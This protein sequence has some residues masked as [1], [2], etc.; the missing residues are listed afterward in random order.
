MRKPSRMLPE[1]HL[2]GI[3][4]HT[5]GCTQQ[6]RCELLARPMRGKLAASWQVAQPLPGPWALPRTWGAPRLRA[7]RW[8]CCAPSAGR[9]GAPEHHGLVPGQRGAGHGVGRAV[10]GLWGRSG[11]MGIAGLVRV[12]CKAVAHGHARQRPRLLSQAG[13]PGGTARAAPA[14]AAAEAEEKVAHTHGGAREGHARLAVRHKVRVAPGAQRGGRRRRGLHR[15]RR[16][17]VRRRG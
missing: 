16:R 12:P 14:A 8:P 7:A 3:G 1:N 15:R 11:G 13:W 4:E 10:V 5:R 2:R 17:R 9:P 6:P